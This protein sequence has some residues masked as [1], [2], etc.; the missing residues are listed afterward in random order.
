MSEGKR[1]P[2][3][4]KDEAGKD[5]ISVV[6]GTLNVRSSDIM[7]STRG[8]GGGTYAHWQI[9]L[10]YAKYLSPELHMQ[11][12]EVFARVK[13]GDVTLAD[14]IAD[15]ASPEQQEWLAKRMNSKVARGRLTSTLAAHGV[16]GKGF[17]DCTNGT[18][19]G[20]FNGTKKEICAATGIE[21]KKGKS[22]RDAMSVEDLIAV[23]M[24][25]MV[26]AKQIDK[27]NVRGNAACADECHR[28]AKKVAGLLQ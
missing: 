16:A 18:Y 9:A 19:K 23:S 3:R 12:N 11:V 28:S 4:W 5:F 14:E 26:A 15:K 27:F 21:Y 22:L 1:D 20:L 24:A 25:E 2:R 10:A 17:G 13:A 8:K 7:K 6:A